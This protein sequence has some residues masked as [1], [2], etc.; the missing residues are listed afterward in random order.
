M[1]P[2]NPANGLAPINMLEIGKTT[3][4]TVLVSNSMKME[5][6]TKVAGKT[7]KDMGKELIGFVMPK[8]N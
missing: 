8:A 3:R 1:A 5:I 6:N 7:I 2:K 4:K